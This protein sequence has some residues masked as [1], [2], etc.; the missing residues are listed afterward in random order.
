MKNVFFVAYEFPPLNSGG[1]HR[2]LNFAKNL[3][4][5]NINPIVIT[6]DTYDEGQIDKGLASEIPNSLQVIR[7]Q[8]R[9]PGYFSE[10][11]KKKLR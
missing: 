10:L 8:I 2:P 11:K 9:E 3:C 1:S 6:V 4:A 7:T 5:F